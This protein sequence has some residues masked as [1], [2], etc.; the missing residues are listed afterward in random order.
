MLDV[1]SRFDPEDHS[2]L[3]RRL[4]L[5]LEPLARRQSVSLGLVQDWSAWC[6]PNVRRP[7]VGQS[8]SIAVGP[9]SVGRDIQLDERWL[10]SFTDHIP[11]V[12]DLVD[13]FDEIFVQC[14]GHPQNDRQQLFVCTRVC[15]TFLERVL[16][17]GLLAAGHP[18]RL[19]NIK[20]GWFAAADRA[21]IGEPARYDTRIF[22]HNLGGR[23]TNTF[24]STLCI[25]DARHV[26]AICRA[27][28]CKLTPPPLLSHVRVVYVDTCKLRWCS[29]GSVVSQS[30]VWP[31]R[32]KEAKGIARILFANH[33]NLAAVLIVFGRCFSSNNVCFRANRA[34][35]DLLWKCSKMGRP[36]IAF[37]DGNDGIGGGDPVPGWFNY[38]CVYIRICVNAI[39]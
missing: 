4:L 7:Y 12:E 23:R 16:V 20:V 21:R 27:P 5:S 38:C 15:N 11:S 24:G 36:Y 18:V 14:Y 10:R 35:E 6:K 8:P 37:C 26:G 13:E 2:G 22:I 17:G 19:R 3:C 34:L 25:S 31:C 32:I 33:C 30:F 39:W 9:P 28:G 29:V 1:C